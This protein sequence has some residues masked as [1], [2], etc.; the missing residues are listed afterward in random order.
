MCAVGSDP[1]TTLASAAMSATPTMDSSAAATAA[2]NGLKTEPAAEVKAED[3]KAVSLHPL[4]Y[5]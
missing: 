2:P 4:Y 5:V 3:D 1:L